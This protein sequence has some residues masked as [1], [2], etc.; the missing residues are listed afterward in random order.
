MQKCNP[1]F[2]ALVDKFY[3]SIEHVRL[4]NGAEPALTYL[5]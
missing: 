3:V 4:Q 2:S 1:F 5:R